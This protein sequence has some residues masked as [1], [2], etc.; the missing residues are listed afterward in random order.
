[1]DS[2][3]N[4]LTDIK[5]AVVGSAGTRDMGTNSNRSTWPMEAITFSCANGR[6]L[7]LIIDTTPLNDDPS[8]LMTCMTPDHSGRGRGGSMVGNGASMGRGMGGTSGFLFGAAMGA[9]TF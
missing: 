5:F 1:M 3:V 9:S 4:G 6:G 7:M 2:A 8:A